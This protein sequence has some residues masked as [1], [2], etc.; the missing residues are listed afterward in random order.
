MAEWIDVCATADIEEE[1][2][3][4]FAHGGAVYVAVRDDADNF[5]VVDGLCTHEHVELAEGFVFGC[6]LE[7]PRHQGRFNLRDGRP[8]G[9]PVTEGLRSYETRVDNGRLLARLD[10]AT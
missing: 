7:C 6:V 10:E 3:L 8:S 9:G 5:Y 1:D 2:V 4:R